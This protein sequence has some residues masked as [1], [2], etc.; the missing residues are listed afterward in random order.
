M[1]YTVSDQ[2][3]LIAIIFY[4]YIYYFYK[5]EIIEMYVVIWPNCMSKSHCLDPSYESLFL[6]LYK[7]L[8]HS[9]S[10]VFRAA[11]GTLNWEG[12]L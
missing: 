2:T 10:V 11:K 5:A 9:E 12:L 8:T 4:F 3:T 1:T 6:D 7:Y